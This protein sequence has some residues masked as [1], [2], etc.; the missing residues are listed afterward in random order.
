MESQQKRTY[1]T[2]FQF[3]SQSLP[4]HDFLGDIESIWNKILRFL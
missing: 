1:T 2:D 4:F 3:F